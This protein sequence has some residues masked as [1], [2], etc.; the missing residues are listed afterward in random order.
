MITELGKFL[1][2]LRIDHGEILYNM[3]TKLG[4]SITFLSSVETGKKNMPSEWV[5]K[6][7]ALYSLSNDQR[8]ILLK[9]I[10]G[11]TNNDTTTNTRAGAHRQHQD[12]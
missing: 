1:R 10:D 8:L 7:S 3:A 4:V 11:R 9:L 5:D 2:R 12:S 6:L